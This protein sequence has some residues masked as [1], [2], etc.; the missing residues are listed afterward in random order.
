MN[1]Y[2]SLLL[3]S[4]I[5]SGCTFTGS[6]RTANTNTGEVAPGNIG[7][8]APAAGGGESQAA[9]A[10]SVVADLYKQHDAKKGPFFQTKDRALVDKYFTK[11]LADLIWKDAVSSAGEVGALDADPLYNAQDIEIKN[12]KVW[13]AEVKGDSATVMV[14]F[15]NYTQKNFLNF[16]LK[17]V[18]DAWKIADFSYGPKETLL[19]WL[20]SAPPET[21]GD[22]L[23]DFRGK[24]IVGDTSCTVEFKNKGY[25]VKWAKGSG[26]EYFSLMDGTTFASSTV[27][28]EANKF[29]FDDEN[30][31]SGTFHRAD[32]KT[33]PIR[34]AK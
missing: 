6:D 15:S 5:F 18:D 14:T 8:S 26:V 2:H 11:Q 17:M 13:P 30:Y 31:N 25:A 28:S 10:E 4:L 9:R 22:D 3:F 23:G 21:A 12:L 33:F 27:E 29:V 7:A 34:R 24:Y 20:T 1:R 32:G 19:T 16:S